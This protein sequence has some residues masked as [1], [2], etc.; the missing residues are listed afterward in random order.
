MSILLRNILLFTVPLAMLAAGE[1]IPLAQGPAQDFSQ[2]TWELPPDADKTA[3]PIASSDESIAKGKELFMTRKGNCVFCHGETGSG[4]EANL[5]KLRRKPADLSDAARMPK[6]SDGLIYW[7][8]T[9][10]ITGIMPAYD[11]PKLTAEERWH[12]VNFVKTLSRE[13]PKSQAT[14]RFEKDKSAMPGSGGGQG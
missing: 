2:N 3:N 1:T 4:N 7:K 6:L 13:K 5:P 10:G 8:I 9:R 14:G 11:D 12:L